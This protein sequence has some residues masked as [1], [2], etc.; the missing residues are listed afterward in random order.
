MIHLIRVRFSIESNDEYEPQSSLLV[1][2]PAEALWPR[3][4]T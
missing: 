2:D 4:P 1:S 3:C